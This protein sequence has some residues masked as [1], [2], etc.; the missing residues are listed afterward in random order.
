LAA[1]IKKFFTFYAM[2]R[3]KSN[4]LPPTF[5]FDPESCDDNRYDMRPY[6]YATDWSY[7]FYIIDER[8]KE[9]LSKNEKLDM[10]HRSA[11]V[12]EL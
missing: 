12:S 1:K 3:H 11:S 8:V 9:I 7:Q 10:C 2:N 5:F 6:I 4:T